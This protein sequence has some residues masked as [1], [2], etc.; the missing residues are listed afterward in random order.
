[1]P[2]EL[3]TGRASFSPEHTG[4]LIIYQMMMTEIEHE[5]INSGL[6]LYLRE[7]VMREVSGTHRERRDLML[8]RNEI[9]YYLSKQNE[10]HC[11]EKAQ[12]DVDN[13]TT[14][15][16]G[17][18]THPL[19]VSNV[20]ELPEPINRPNAC[21]SCPYNILCSVYLNRDSK[22]LS[23]LDSKHPLRE[24]APLITV[25]LTEAHINYFF[26][27]VGLMSLEDQENKKS[28][29]KSKF[30]ISAIHVLIKF[31]NIKSSGYPNEILWLETPENRQK[32][33]RAIFDLKLNSNVEE[34]ESGRY[35]HEFSTNCLDLTSFDFGVGNYL[36]VSTRKRCSV[37]A[38][39]VIS[40][41]KNIIVLSLDR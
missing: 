32:C 11:G 17:S 33:G 31:A 9:S 23:S 19:Q 39:P 37:A 30:S 36:I 18:V 12:F 20:P 15:E 40:V 8:L 21:S 10:S 7:G 16:D 38:G 13:A 24:T 5:S 35:I 4:Q 2:L 6:L 26:H 28:R 41:E 34:E 25:H 14:S 3:K 29:P 27:W 1:M 22:T